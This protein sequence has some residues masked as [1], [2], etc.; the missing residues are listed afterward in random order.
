MTVSGLNRLISDFDFY[1][2]TTP[3][4]NIAHSYCKIFNT[5]KPNPVT[6]APP[7]RKMDSDDF[8]PT[9]FY[10]C[11]RKVSRVL[12]CSVE[13]YRARGK[14]APYDSLG[15]VDFLAGQVTI[16]SADLHYGQNSRQVIL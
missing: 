1:R 4:I 10:G 5:P 11:H 14:K 6:L 8:R 9:P 15:Q 7:P 13:F 2:L 16:L 12:P 3:G